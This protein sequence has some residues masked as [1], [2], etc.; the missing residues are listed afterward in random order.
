M[1]EDIAAAFDNF[2]RAFDIARRLY[3]TTAPSRETLAAFDTAHR[4]REVLR[5]T[6]EDARAATRA[7]NAG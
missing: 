1:N 4:M 2:S 3:K 5:A 7:P 6:I